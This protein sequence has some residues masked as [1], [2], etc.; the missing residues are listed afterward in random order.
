MGRLAGDIKKRKVSALRNSLLKWYEKEARDFPWRRTRDPYK[1]LVSEILLQ[2]TTSKQVSGIY[3]PFFERYPS[4]RELAG[5][6][7]GEIK[8]IVGKL[9][10]EKRADFLKEA[11]NKI[12]NEYGGKIP[13]SPEF[14]KSLKGVGN[15][16]CNSVL[17]F[18]FGVPCHIVDNNVARVLRRYF[19]LD[20]TK[21]AHSD[22]E[23]WKVAER[24]LPLKKFREFNYALLD[25]A[26]LICKPKNPLHEQ[27][28][29]KKLCIYYRKT[30]ATKQ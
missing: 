16:V 5:T 2:K 10:L 3:R 9:G 11:A 24:V 19:G 8:E 4:V 13:E 6:S 29:L 17:C 12:V 15:Y 25:F 1:V 21:R 7:T 14:L 30:G 22:K 27:C 18:A 28:P 20:S 23:L 26:A